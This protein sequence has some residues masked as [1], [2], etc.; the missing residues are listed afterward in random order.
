MQAEGSASF[1]WTIAAVCGHEFVR[2][3]GDDTDQFHARWIYWRECLK[4]ADRVHAHV[5]RF[6][7]GRLNYSPQETDAIGEKRPVD[8]QIGC[9]ALIVDLAGTKRS[10]YGLHQGDLGIRASSG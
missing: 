6:A 7:L 10:T 9:N 4:I 8:I 3:L 5:A 1:S 2:V